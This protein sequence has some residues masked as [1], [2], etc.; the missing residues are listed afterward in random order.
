VS[1]F[2]CSDLNSQR[3]NDTISPMRFNLL[4]QFRI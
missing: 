1:A 4:S 3:E 2:L